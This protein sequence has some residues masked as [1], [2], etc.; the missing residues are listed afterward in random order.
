MSVQV[1]STPSV[2]SQVWVP[3]WQARNQTNSTKLDQFVSL[4]DCTKFIYCDGNEI[5]QILYFD[6]LF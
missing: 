5:E 2:P 1:D 6:I 4:V 3:S